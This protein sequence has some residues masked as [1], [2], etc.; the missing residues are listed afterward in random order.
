M[1]ETICDVRWEGPFRWSKRPHFRKPNHVLY[2]LYGTHH[3]YGQN[4]L[5]YLGK[6][7]ELLSTRLAEHKKWV[8]GEYDRM[9]VRIASVGEF[10][11]VEAWWKAW[12]TKKRYKKAEPDVVDRIEALLIYANQPAYNSRLKSQANSTS[13]MLRIFNTGHWGLLLPE[14]SHA[15]FVEGDKRFLL[16]WAAAPPL[17]TPNSR[18]E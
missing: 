4:Q 3:L 12:D 15:Y 7:E 11:T 16:G 8:Q 1:K 2:A 9:L 13:A 17:R 6:T 14:I 5:L 18:S 10:P